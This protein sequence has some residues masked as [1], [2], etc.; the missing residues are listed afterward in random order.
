MNSPARQKPSRIPR[1]ELVSVPRALFFCLLLTVSSGRGQTPTRQSLFT[2]GRETMAQVD[3]DFWLTS[4]RLYAEDFTADMSR[5]EAEKRQPSFMWGC[6][7]QLS[8]LATATALDRMNFSARLNAYATGLDAYWKEGNG[9]SGYDVLP[10]KGGGTD[11]Y[12]DDNAW[13][14]LAMIDTYRVTRD[15]QYLRRAEKTMAFVMSG[16]DKEL[17]GGLYWREQEKKTKNTCTNAPAIVAALRLYQITKT[18]NYL[19]AAQRT[20]TWMNAHLQDADGLY[21]DNIALNGDIGRAKFSYNTA[22]MLRAN[23]EFYRV[24]RDQKY[25]VE[26]SRIADASLA[27][28][29]TPEGGITDSARFAHLLLGAFIELNSVAP[30]PKWRQP[31]ERVLAYLHDHLKD[32]AG[33]YPENWSKPPAEPIKKCML[34]DEASVGRAYWEAAAAFR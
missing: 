1:T 9:I 28:W 34:L 30:A 5:T 11:R 27:K 20:Y 18:A 31:V 16:E 22:L 4:R 8:A 13:I 24:T 6:G 15:L 25:L 3:R 21:W 17:G 32:K 26:A 7:V 2:W 23:V 29:F 19:E 14:V 12:Y 10:G 33:R